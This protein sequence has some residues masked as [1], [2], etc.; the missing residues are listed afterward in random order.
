[1]AVLFVAYV[2]SFLDRQILSLLVA[3]LERDLALNDTQVSLLQGL[4]FAVC[5]GL[6]GLPLGRL[7]DTRRRT[8]IVSAGV[9]FWSVMT[10]LCGVASS[11]WTLFVCRMG[12]GVGEAS[13]TPSAYSIIADSV[14][15][16]RLGLALGVFTVGVHVGS[17]L[18]LLLGAAAVAAVGSWRGV[19]FVI[20]LPGVIVALWTLSLR[21]P[22][23]QQAASVAPSMS[24]VLAYLRANARSLGAVYFCM[25]FAAMTSYALNAWMATV[26]IRSFGWTA[27]LAGRAFG[28]LVI[29]F[30]AL[31]VLAGGMLGDFVSA[32]GRS[33]G[34]LLVMAWAAVA[35][36]PFALA[37]PLAS[38]PTSMLLLLGPMIFFAT[39]VI[40]LGPS[41]LPELVPNQ[42][43]GMATSIGVLIVNLLGLGLGP[44]AV[45]L[46]TDYIIRDER[47]VRYSLAALLP[48]MLAVS[49]AAGFQGLRSYA[50]SRE[51]LGCW[52]TNANTRRFA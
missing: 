4:A 44:T 35:A 49:A 29:V 6:G 38:G 8:A 5:N 14:Q 40:G 12:V 3:P 15:P 18:A 31:G 30:G 34:R 11:F 51:Y 21:E 23:R 32:R 13:L 25:A 22:V 46:V 37:A 28:P 43:R 9:A 19:F 39:M 26:L 42:M 33:N 17:G 41:T 48:C 1:V 24:V 10:A 16:R 52:N 20:G 45:A 2:F 27:A 7:V 36:V 47:L 50:R